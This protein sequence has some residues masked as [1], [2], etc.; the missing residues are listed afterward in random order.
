MFCHVVRIYMEYANVSH[1]MSMQL[2][3]KDFSL[4]AV[5]YEI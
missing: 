5:E 1:S 4:Y 3:S 2:N